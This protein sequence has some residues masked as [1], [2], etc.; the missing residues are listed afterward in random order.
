MVDKTSVFVFLYVYAAAGTYATRS[1]SSAYAYVVDE[2]V[3]IVC[4]V[5][6]E[7]FSSS[8]IAKADTD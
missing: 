4:S 3:F 2:R 6:A 5:R 7:L 1:S 8:F